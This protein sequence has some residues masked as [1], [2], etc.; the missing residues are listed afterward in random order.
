MHFYFLW[1]AVLALAQQP[2][3]F[4]KGGADLATWEAGSSVVLHLCCASA[5]E[6]TASPSHKAE[7]EGAVASAV[8]DFA[9]ATDNLALAGQLNWK[10]KPPRKGAPCYGCCNSKRETASRVWDV[11]IENKMDSK[12]WSGAIWRV[13]PSFRLF[14]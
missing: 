2:E 1:V 9:T 3:P 14:T 11:A 7:V 12:L 6:D 8:V 10:A 4:P 13:L 5:A